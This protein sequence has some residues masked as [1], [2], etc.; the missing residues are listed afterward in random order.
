MGQLAHANQRFVDAGVGLVMLS[1][2][3]PKRARQL[4]DAAASRPDFPVLSDVDADATVAYNVF[5]DGIAIASTFLI[6]RD[7]R[8]RWTHVADRPSDRPT[9][10]ALLAQVALLRAV[11]SA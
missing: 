4:A 1:V 6:D 10:D 9:V 5:A 8:I 3:S 2:D 11:D 7:G